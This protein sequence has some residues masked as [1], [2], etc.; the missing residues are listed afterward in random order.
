[1]IY[2]E[3]SEKTIS[4]FCQRV[5]ANCKKIEEIDLEA[6]NKGTI[7]HRFIYEPI[8]DGYAVYQIV[9]ENKKTVRIRVCNGIGDD[10]QVPYWGEEA[11]ITK[12]YAE[13]SLNR[14]DRISELFNKNN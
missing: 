7:L 11:T 14:R 13:G 3:I 10:W 12:T 5:D 6:K 1:M 2:K 8:A 4:D 9:K